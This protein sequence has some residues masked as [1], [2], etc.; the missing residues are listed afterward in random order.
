M[1]PQELQN[2]ISDSSSWVG[3]MR[4]EMGRVL[5]GQTNLVNKLLIGLL[6][7]G[8]ILLEGV[9]GLAKTLAVKALAGSLRAEFARIQFTPDLLPADLLGTMIYHPDQKTFAPKLGP[10]FANLILADEINRAPAKVQSAL[11]EAMQER[12]VT[13][14]DQSYDLPSP[15]LVLA[16]QNPIDQEGTYSLPEAQLDRFLLKITVDYPSREEE[17]E[18][19]DRMSSSD[20][21]EETSAVTTTETIAENR[22]L[23]DQIYIDSAV[24]GYIV[25]LV[26]A[27]RTPGNYESSLKNLIMAGASPRATINFARA[28]RAN[29]FLQGRAFVTPGDIKELAPEILRHRILLSYE[30]EAENVTTD[31]I[32]E[33]L[34]S[35]V[36][37][38]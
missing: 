27:T 35:R 36:P 7:N 25:D 10:I 28:A 15:F 12:Q 23:I 24:R 20:A 37:V 8:H 33:R 32:V 11:L 2:K 16:T 4:S 9:P 17:L 6:S 38:P 3:A 14:G 1:D 18:I 30:A 19:L 34:M 26:Q 29:A 31:Q 5:V 13:I 22:K 21:N